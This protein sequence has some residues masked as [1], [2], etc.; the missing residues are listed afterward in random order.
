MVKEKTISKVPFMGEG[1]KIN[2]GLNQ[3]GMRSIGE[4]LFNKLLPGLNNVSSRIRYYSFYCWLFSRFY[5]G[6]EEAKV[7]D[8]QFYYKKAE[9]L[10]ALINSDKTGIP[11]STY[12]IKQKAVLQNEY[13]LNAGVNGDWENKKYWKNPGGV[14]TQYYVRSMLDIGIIGSIKDTH[15]IP[16]L[17]YKPMNVGIDLAESFEESVTKDEADK[18]LHIVQSGVVKQS[19]LN[20]LSVAFDMRSFPEN[21]IERSL[22]VELLLDVDYPTKEFSD[23][24]RQ[25]TIFYLLEYADTAV[26]PIRD[27]DFVSYMYSR[28]HNSTVRDNTLW[29]WYAYFINEDWQ[30]QSSFVFE[31]LIDTFLKKKENGRWVSIK[32]ITEDMVQVIC[33]Y[34]DVP[35]STLLCEVIDRID[36]IES[37]KDDAS[38]GI[39]Q[40]LYNYRQNLEIQKELAPLRNAFQALSNDNYFTFMQNISKRTNESFGDFLRYFIVEEIIYRHYQEAFRKMRVTGIATQKFSL[41]GGYIKYLADVDTTHSSPRLETLIEFLNDLGI[42]ENDHLTLYGKQILKKLSHDKSA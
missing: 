26:T 11:G 32:I 33:D 1:I 23:R 12:A 18:F 15:D 35:E 8:F 27:L 34:L 22:L 30:Y 25:R 39:R 38:A 42:I 19:E 29:G 24:N 2:A 14:F 17:L 10:L 7:S 20:K 4:Q 5:E 41:E 36:D 6:I 16:T 9:Y 37:P 21:S 40:L 28:F 3:L 13:A 31:E